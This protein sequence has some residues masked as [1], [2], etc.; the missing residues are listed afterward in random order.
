M[1]FPTAA[2]TCLPPPQHLDLC[3][4]LPGGTAIC[5][6]DVLNSADPFQVVQALLQSVNTALAPLQPIFDI[7]GVVEAVVLCIQAI[8]KCLAPPNP[9]PLVK[10]LPGLVE[11]VAKIVKLLPPLSM[12]VTIVDVV[13]AVIAALQAFVLRLQ[14][15]VVK[16]ARLL[17]A[18]A[19]ASRPGN[20]ALGLVVACAS[21]NLSVELHNLNASLGP[22]NKLIGLVNLLGQ[23]VPG[24]PQPLVPSLD[25]LGADAEAAIQ[26][27]VD[28]VG[29]LA[30]V[31]DGVP[32]P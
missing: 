17:A 10:C 29:V 1:R 21:G 30:Q 12:P 7:V 27:L 8:P 2:L 14:A 13:R 31:A 15:V 23:A 5:A 22:I 16:N 9:D 32:L 4:T 25:G 18:A 26:P 24:L 6:T 3:V 20:E 19:K 28:V 11:A